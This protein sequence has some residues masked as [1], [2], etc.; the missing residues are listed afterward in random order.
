MIIRARIILTALITL[1]SASPLF[2]QLPG[3]GVKGG[4]NLATEK[5]SGEDA[6]DDDFTTFPALV[7]GVF[8]TYKVAPGLEFQPEA[9]YSVKG[10][11]VK[12]TGFTSTVHLDYLEV[13]LLARVSKRGGGRMGFYAA[14]GPYVA[15]LLRARTRTEFGPSTEELDVSEQVERADFGVSIGGG[16]EW[17]RVVV[18]GR[19]VYGLRDIDKDHGDGIKIT[20]RAIAITAGFRF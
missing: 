20:N 14:G 9:L 19:Y 13:P 7:A 17:G 3:L 8:M 12:E 10:A 5:T 15:Y 16:V 1:T 2:A 11:R 18:D 6:G 4:V